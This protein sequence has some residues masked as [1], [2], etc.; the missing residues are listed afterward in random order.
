[1]YMN[2]VHKKFHLRRKPRVLCLSYFEIELTHNP[3]LA[4]MRVSPVRCNISLY[5]NGKPV[6]LINF[7]TIKC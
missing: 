7:Y 1:M 4:A 6:L 3:W 2:L 5:C